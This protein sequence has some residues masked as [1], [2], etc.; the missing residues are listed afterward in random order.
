MFRFRQFSVDDASC[1]MKVGTDGVLLG[2]WAQAGAPLRILDIG[3]GSGLIA[4]MLA[5]RYPQATVTA[6]DIEAGA[7]A[8][9]E[10]NFR[11]SPWADRLQAVHCALQD[12][13]SADRFDLIVSNPPY[14]QNSLKTPD[15]ARTTARHT[16]TLTYGTLMTCSSK[17]LHLQ[18]TLALVL[19]AWEETAIRDIALSHRLYLKQLCRIRGREGKLFRRILAAFCKEQLLPQEE[20]LTL[21]NTPGQRS[22]G[23]ALLTQDFYL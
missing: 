21:E 20:E 2:A 3:T 14:F 1:A 13:R 6:I 16:D 15:A 11:Q 23:Y 22:T 7:V 19:P 5:Q 8:Q 10:R 17:L 12:F 18:G 9:A 4:L